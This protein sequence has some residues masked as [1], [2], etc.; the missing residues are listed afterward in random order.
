MENLSAFDAFV[1]VNNGSGSGSGSGSGYGFG[2]GDGYGYGDSYGYGDGFGE[3][4]GCGCDCGRCN[5][6]G[7]GYGDGDGGG[8]G[9]GD[10]GGSGRGYGGGDGG[11]RGIKMFTRNPVY[12]IDETPTLMYIVHG[13]IAKG[14]ILKA[15]LTTKP[16][17]IVKNGNL[18]AHGETLHEAQSALI[19][20]QF[21]DMDDDDRINAFLAEIDTNKQYQTSVF[22]EWHHRLTGSCEM[23]RRIFAENHGIDL[24]N[25]AMTVSEFV[26]LT[27]NAYGGSIIKKIEERI[28]IGGK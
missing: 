24:E 21:E 4:C 17:Y 20:K 8:Y 2:F 13:N 9:Y 19:E 7:N 12:S 18:F 1:Q 27:K 15:D 25:G 10:G 23:G 3:G 22:F 5:D 16:C 11:G 6:S 26:E 14:A 28:K